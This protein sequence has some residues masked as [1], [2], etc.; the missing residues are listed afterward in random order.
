MSLVANSIKEIISIKIKSRNDSVTDQYQRIFMTKICIVFAALIGV[1]Y[2]NDKVSC[3]VANTNGMSDSFVGTTCWIQGFYVFEEMINRFEDCGYYGIPKNMEHDGINSLGHLCAVNDRALGKI[4]GCYPMKKK[5]YDQYQYMPFFIASLAILF[6]LPYVIFKITNSDLMS[7]KDTLN[8]KEVKAEDIVSAYFNVKTNS[9]RKM[10]L[11]V[12]MSVCIKFLYLFANVVAFIL[13]DVLLN[14]D[15]RKYGLNYVR[16]IRSHSF[17]GLTSNGLKSQTEPK[18]GYV[19]LPAMGFCEI[20]EAS[21]DNRNS[22]INSHRFICE[23]S[24]HLLYQYVM[25]VFWFLLVFGIGISIAGVVVAMF[26]YL[27]NFICLLSKDSPAKKI[28]RIVTFREIDYLECIRRKNLPLYSDVLYSL[29]EKRVKKT[30]YSERKFEHF[31][32]V[33]SDR[34]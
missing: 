19:L 14:G 2:F 34:E 30:K 16:W 33:K 28:Y 1:N 15:F 8:N 9:V 4:F 22:Y 26:G 13:C 25:L 6:Y 17:I 21:R 31:A 32:F 12:I 29:K 23:I 27:I 11:R 20:H 7:L 18:P 10:K 5:Y 3:I 24:P